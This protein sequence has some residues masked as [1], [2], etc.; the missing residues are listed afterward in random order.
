MPTGRGPLRIAIEDFINTGPLRGLFRQSVRDIAEE[1]EAEIIDEYRV[2]I[3]ELLT[4][5]GVDKPTKQ[6]IMRPFTGERQ[7]GAAIGS[8]IVIALIVGLVMACVG[9]LIEILEHLPNSLLTPKRFNPQEAIIAAWRRPNE[10][11]DILHDPKDLGWNDW[12]RNVFADVLRPRLQEPSLMGLWW[13]YPDRRDDVQS[14]L[15]RRGW[16][17]DT[18]NDL[19][20]ATENFPGPTDIVRMAVREAFTPS[21]IERFGLMSDFP[22]R[23]ASEMAKLG[24]AD[25]YTNAYWVA[26]WNLPSPTQAYEMYHRLRP[27]TTTSPFTGDDLDVLLRTLDYPPYW[28]ER[29]RQISYSLPRLVD[30]RSLYS[31]GVWEPDDV[32]G[33]YLDRGYAP[34][35]ADA[36]TALTTRETQAVELDIS[37]DTFVTAYYRG[38]ISESE[39]RSNLAA[40]GYNQVTIDFWVDYTDYRKNEKIISETLDVIEAQ[41]LDGTLTDAEAHGRL[42]QLPLTPDQ[43]T[44]RMTLWSIRRE[45]KVKLPTTASLKW[46][47][48]NGLVDDGYVRD[49][50]TRRYI[51]EREQSLILERWDI[52]TQEANTKE[53]ER[54]QK[55]RERLESSELRSDYALERAVIDV[56]IAEL[57]VQLADLNV[58]RHQLVDASELADLAEMVDVIK[59]DI[60]SLQRDKAD[61]TRR[62]RE[63]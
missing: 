48:Q 8:A 63:G 58:V 42:S 36:L 62:Y 15:A 37:R 14:E 33:A 23:F 41:Y 10:Q 5:A 44:N 61:L 7:T 20:A 1:W 32:R 4:Q 16:S 38:A 11:E 29:L 30:I 25:E 39:L 54:A 31:A 18:I 52:E 21:V 9:P 28:R 35:I 26:H 40:I 47:Y 59:Y 43:I 17:P 57:R 49:I 50:L 34:D 27:G 2:W 12:R 51:T 6:M 55:E 56:D 46:Y 22:S 13:R 45:R 24:Y 60:V 19:I 53:A 3:D